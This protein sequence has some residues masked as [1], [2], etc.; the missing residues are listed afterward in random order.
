M[1]FTDG[2][3]SHI[4]DTSYT[5]GPVLVKQ[6]WR[7]WVNMTYEPLS[8]NITRTKQSLY[9]VMYYTMLKADQENASYLNIEFFFDKTCHLLVTKFMSAV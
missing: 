8:I 1:A 2:L 9:S 7:I 4:D 6:A 5:F 3:V